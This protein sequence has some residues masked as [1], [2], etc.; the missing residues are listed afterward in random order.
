MNCAAAGFAL[1]AAALAVSASGQA[2]NSLHEPPAN[3][4]TDAPKLGALLAGAEGKA[5]AD[6]RAWSRRREA[7]RQQWLAHLGPLPATRPA[8][9]A[10]VLATEDLP[11]F[12][13]QHVRY[14]VEEGLFTDGYLLTPKGAAGRLPAVAVFHQTIGTQAQQPAGVDASTPELMH[15]V[16]LVERGYVVLCPRC[17]IFA[18]GAD[19]AGHV[20]AMHARHPD[21]TGMLRL[22]WDAIR[23]ADYLQ[24]LP[25]VDGD[26]LGCLGHS[27][28]AKE[29]LYAVAFDERYKVAVFS[30]GGIGLSF[31]NWDAVWY[32]GPG[33]R[34][35][36]FALEHHQLIALA[37]PRAFLLLA[38]DSADG[39]KSWA[40]VEAALPVYRLLGAPGNLGWFN[41]HQGHRYPADAQTVAEAFLDAHLT[42]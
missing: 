33:I 21:W 31:S 25:Q 10:E 17:F 24:S 16:Q 42:R 23:A 14:Q 20:A 4:P 26:R 27:L 28:G 1:M 37:A 15:G 30:E 8:L 32:L 3:P 18:E 39:D 9:K 41:H 12:V 29:V 35:P 36:D 5:I 22:T 19:Y 11:G 6:A 2:T 7:L 13:R 38:G 40:F 34:R